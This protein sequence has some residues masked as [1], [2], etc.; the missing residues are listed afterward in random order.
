MAQIRDSARGAP[1]NIAEGFSR[2]IPGETLRFISFAQASLDETKS[3]TFDA[4]ECSYFS[5]DETEAVLRLIR[6]TQGAIRKWRAYLESPAAKRF[7]EQYKE[8]RRRQEWQPPPN[9]EP[10]EPE[11]PEEP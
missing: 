5:D 10:E 4:H 11:E 2:F 1:R 6:R 7:Y 8:R 9:Q 3:H